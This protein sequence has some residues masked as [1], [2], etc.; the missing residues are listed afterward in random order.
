T[1][2]ELFTPWGDA[3]VHMHL[4]GRFNIHNALAAVAV[5]GLL[6]IDLKKMVKTLAE[7]PAIPGRLE[8]VKNRRGKKVF[9]DYAH[10]DDALKNVLTTLREICKGRLIVVF[11][12]GG[13]RDQGKRLK[14]GKVASELADYSIVTSDNPRNEDPGA[15]A[16]TI[17]EGYNDQTQFE[18][19]LDRREAIE[20]GLR[21]AGRKDVLLIAGKGHETYQEFKGTISPFDDRETVREILG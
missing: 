1:R 8:L 17:I 7:I 3:L 5:G 20:T 4:L 2:F 21:M 11:G 12:C 9:V 14:M 19:V 18:V 6:G 13:N 16:A 15:I 10:T